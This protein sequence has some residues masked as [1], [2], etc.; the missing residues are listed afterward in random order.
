M[1]RTG[2]ATQLPGN[3]SIPQE[4]AAPDPQQALLMGNAERADVIVDFSGMPNGT[5]I[6][7]INTAPDSP[8]GGFPV[9]P[10]DLADPLTT[11]Q[12]MDFIVNTALTVTSDSAT[13][14]P[15]DL[16]LPA[17]LPLGAATNTRQVSLNEMESDQ[18]CVE[19]D[20]VTG[21]YVQTLFSTFTGDP[22][23]PDR[24]RG[25]P[26]SAPLVT[27]RRRWRLA[28]QEWAS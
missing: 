28:R 4:V 26:L 13:T 18:V 23:L 27:L 24:L 12:V 25:V 8:F 15:Q 14:D 19:Y 6:R 9:A 16:V 7:M 20:A 1:I 21:A 3:G 22:E 10:V 17:E 2:F 11:G 5:R